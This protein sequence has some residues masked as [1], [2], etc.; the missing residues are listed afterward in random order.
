[1]TRDDWVLAAMAGKGEFEFSPV[2]VQKLMFMIEK[3][4]AQDKPRF[5]FAAYDYGPFDVDVYHVLESLERRGL[6]S[7]FD[8]GVGK[9]RRYSLTSEGLTKGGGLLAQLEPPLAEYIAKLANWVASL[10][11]AQLV[12]A[13]YAKYP[14][15]KVNSVFNY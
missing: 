15:M 9:F 13:V 3:N 14:E 10:S 7:I 8:T 4:V 5:N 11:F 6:V 12:S 2:Q 1:M